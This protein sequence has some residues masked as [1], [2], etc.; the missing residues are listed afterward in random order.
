MSGDFGTCFWLNGR[1]WV[2]CLIWFALSL[3]TLTWMPKTGVQNIVHLEKKL[4]QWPSIP[5]W[6]LQMPECLKA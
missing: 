3:L 2:A 5:V 1:Y 6:Q 4:L